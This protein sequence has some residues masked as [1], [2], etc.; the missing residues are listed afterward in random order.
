MAENTEGKAKETA[1]KKRD[2]RGRFLP[3][4]EGGPGRAP[5]KKEERYYQLTREAVTEDDWLAIVHTTI[6]RAKKGDRW[7]REWL[8]NYLLGRPVQR[9]DASIVD[10]SLQILYVNDWRDDPD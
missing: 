2:A 5:A 1:V 4:W 9:V 3:G 6:I 8:G 7:A 10:Q